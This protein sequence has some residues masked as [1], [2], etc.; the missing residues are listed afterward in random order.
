[1]CGRAGGPY[2]AAVS[3]LPSHRGSTL[4]AVLVLGACCVFWGVSFPA[5]QY[6]VHRLEAAVSSHAEPGAMAGTVAIS[7]TFNAWRFGAAALLY[8][9]ITFPAQRGHGRHEI[10]GGLWIGALFAGGML[11]QVHGLRYTLPSVSG[12]L[13]ALA[14]VFAPAAQALLLRR[15][16]GGETWAA[17][18]IAVGGMA[19]LSAADSASA[20]ALA[21]R[22]PVHALGE[23]LT[24]AGAVLFTG[25]ILAVDHFGRR[26]NTM[27]LTLVMFM[28]TALLSLLTGLSAGGQ[29]LYRAPVLAALAADGPFIGAMLVLVVFSSVLAL[30]LMNAYQ[31]RVAPATATVVYCL[32]PVMATAF[33]AALGAERLLWSTAAGGAVILA[34]VMIVAHAAMRPPRRQSAPPVAAAESV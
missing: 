16:V 8:G 12:F 11:L 18:A 30:H 21:Q 6:A 13:T 24:V 1:L 28:C 26:G 27:R 25:Q 29:A 34:A 33:S 5:M 4:A 17:V 23:M 10:A 19:M 7:A 32:E 14:V 2:D 31:P 15:R 3:M 9:L 20:G 22:P